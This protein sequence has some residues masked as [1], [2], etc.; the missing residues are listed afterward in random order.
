M[1]QVKLS[2]R[3][4]KI[5][6]NY[7][8]INPSILFRPGTVLRTMHPQKTIL[9]DAKIVEEFESEFAIY[10]LSRFIGVLSLFKDPAIQIH[11][12][13]LQIVEGNKK[14][15]YTFAS[16]EQITVP[17]DKEVKLPSE[18]VKFKLTNDVFTDIVKASSVMGLPE[19]A[20]VGENGVL[21]LQGLN[22]KI[23]TSDTYVNEIGQ[24]DNT[25]QMIF[26]AEN[27][28]RLIDE[29]SYDVVICAK[30]MASFKSDNIQYHISLETNSKFEG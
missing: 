5:L 21:K 25:F 16:K 19:I 2:D 30:G 28:M 10:D 1:Y 17:S 9:V 8:T 15:N 24:T 12:K 26:K 6:K 20:V 29:P 7:S 23:P 13:Y 22:S 27:F 14:L 18:D 3:T 4:L 11:D